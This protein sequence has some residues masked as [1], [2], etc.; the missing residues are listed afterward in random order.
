MYSTQDAKHQRGRWWEHGVTVGH[1]S[2]IWSL[3][4]SWQPFSPWLMFS[5]DN[6]WPLNLC[7]LLL[8]MGT[9][10]AYTLL[11]WSAA[12]WLNLCLFLSLSVRS[13]FLKELPLVYHTPMLLNSLHTVGGTYCIVGGYP[14]PWD[15]LEVIVAL[16]KL[17]SFLTDKLFCP[18]GGAAT[19]H[20]AVFTQWTR[21]N[22]HAQTPTANY[23]LL[24]Q[25]THIQINPGMPVFRSRSH[26]WVA[27]HLLTANF[28]HIFSQIGWHRIRVS[29]FL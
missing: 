28:C 11:S 21:A 9:I 19:H 3:P 25:C 16:L 20:V 22:T 17:S 14:K 7:F 26:L 23:P 24:W 27:L 2:Q 29:Q 4:A 10:V 12:L 1:Q 5:D 6:I 8:W 13:C 18:E 15:S